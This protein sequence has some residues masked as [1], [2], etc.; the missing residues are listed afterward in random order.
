M[1]IETFDTLVSTIYELAEEAMSLDST[2]AERIAEIRGQAERARINADHAVNEIYHTSG[3]D[4]GRACVATL[5]REVQVSLLM[6]R[7]RH[8]W[9]L[10]PD[11]ERRR[12][13]QRTRELAYANLASTDPI[14][15]EQARETLAS[16]RSE[17]SESR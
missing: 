15:R 7:A 10:D 2:K 6:I 14:V 17:S 9:I 13:A 3:K 4:A 8:R 12:S 5:K 11:G 16:L 1:T